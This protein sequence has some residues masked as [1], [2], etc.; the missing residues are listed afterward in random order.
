MNRCVITA[1][2][3]LGCALPAWAQRIFP[4]DALRGR[5]AITA[6]PNVLLNGDPARLSPGSRIYGANNLIQ[7]PGTLLGQQFVVD[8]TI[9]I[10]GQIGRVWILTDAEAAVSPWPS[11]PQEARGWRYDGATGRWTQP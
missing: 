6:P 9:D 4:P 3:A 2:L 8:Y 1:A 10:G 7:L 5:I 11:T